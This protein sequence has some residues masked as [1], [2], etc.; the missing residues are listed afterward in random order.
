M[1]K[2]ILDFKEMKGEEK[3]SMITSYDFPSAVLAEEVGFD[4]ILV[5]DSVANTVLGMEDTLSM[6]MQDMIYHTEAVLRGAKDTFVVGDM[7][8]MSY[9]VDEKDAVRNASSFVE[10]GA[11]AVKLEGGEEISDTVNAITN[12]GIPVMGHIG[13]NP[14]RYLD[15]GGYRL[16]GQTSEEAEAILKD[17]MALQEAGAFAIIMEFTTQEATEMVTNRLKIPVIGIGCGGKCDGQVLV[18]H[19]VLGLTEDV[20][21]FAKPYINLREKIAEAFEDFNS[22]IKQ[23]EFP[24]EQHSFHMDENEKEKLE[25][26]D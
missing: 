7:P 11:D 15:L 1:A 26:L 12:V 4:M 23:G 9:E 13:L 19:D 5:G 17:A 20:P 14:Q 24:V 22:E 2:N 10:I 18:M 21:P 3:I 25:D 16:M 6:S 8:F